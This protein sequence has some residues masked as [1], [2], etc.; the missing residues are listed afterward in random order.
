MQVSRF[1]MEREG[2][3]ASREVRAASGHKA[4]SPSVRPNFP[5]LFGRASV[6][7]ALVRIRLDGCSKRGKGRALIADRRFTH[8]ARASVQNSHPG[9]SKFEGLVDDDLGVDD[10]GDVEGKARVD[11]G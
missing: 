9:W 1:G 8:C 10:H 11:G 3:G 4:I 2:E 6:L 5:R 7:L